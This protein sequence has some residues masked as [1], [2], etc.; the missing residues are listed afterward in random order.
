MKEQANTSCRT[1]EAP[2]PEMAQFW[3]G[4]EYRAKIKTR[5]E[6]TSTRPSTLEA[7][8]EI[9]RGISLGPRE[10]PVKYFE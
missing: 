2:D 3:V 7:Q 4:I 6:R 5:F 8:S 9:A 1:L 10:A